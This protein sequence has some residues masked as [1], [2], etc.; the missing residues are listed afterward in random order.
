[1]FFSC[2]VQCSSSFSQVEEPPETQFVSIYPKQEG[3]DNV[4]KA[5]REIKQNDAYNVKLRLNDSTSGDTLDEDDFDTYILE[6][7]KKSLEKK[8]EA[9]AEKERQRIKLL[10][11]EEKLDCIEEENVSLNNKTDSLQVNVEKSQI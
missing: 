7:R 6:L 10:N 11:K 5:L 8:A 9:E 4:W 2:S 1:M 3:E